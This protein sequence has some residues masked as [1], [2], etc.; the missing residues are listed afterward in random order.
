MLRS[1]ST[2]S[3]MANP[4][5]DETT[6]SKRPR[7]PV[8]LAAPVLLASDAE[9]KRRV[10]VAIVAI[11]RVVEDHTDLLIALANR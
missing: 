1:S 11:E 3:S 2:S 8:E 7:A 4:A 9:R 6:G 10:D 5:T